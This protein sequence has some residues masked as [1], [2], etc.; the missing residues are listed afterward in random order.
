MSTDHIERQARHSA[1]RIGDSLSRAA[2][3]AQLAD[4]L[5]LLTGIQS[6][7]HAA[8]PDGQQVACTVESQIATAKLGLQ[9]L[10]DRIAIGTVYETADDDT[11]VEPVAE[12]TAYA[13]VT[14]ED[15]QSRITASWEDGWTAGMVA[16]QHDALVPA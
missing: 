16:A 7:L 15:Y 13:W 3:T 1:A 9:M 5:A 8:Q 12:P 11:D 4:A 2:L 14:V 10:A 6:G